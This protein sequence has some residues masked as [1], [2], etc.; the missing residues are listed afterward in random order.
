M[1]RVAATEV[2]RHL[3]GEHD[4]LVLPNAVEVGP[5]AATSDRL[6]GTPVRLV[7]TMRIARRKR[8]L[9]LLRMLR[10]RCGVRPPRRC[11]SPSSATAPDGVAS[12]GGS[13]ATTPP[14]WSP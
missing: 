11:T 6:A 8:P 7:S 4:V 13:S 2:A 5:R 9:P 3:L 14:T 12:S 10:R 1:S